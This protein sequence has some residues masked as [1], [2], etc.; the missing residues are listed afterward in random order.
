VPPEQI[1]EA[2]TIA[3]TAGYR[4]I[5]TAQGY[6]NEEG[7]GRALRRSELPRDEVFITTKLANSAHGTDKARRAFEESLRKLG[8][9]EVDLFLIHWPVPARDL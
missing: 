8:L 2:V 6:E 1:A 3:L 9:D 5:D 4:L 7:V